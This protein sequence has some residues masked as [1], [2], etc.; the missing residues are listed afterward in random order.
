MPVT[1]AALARGTA[2]SGTNTLLFTAGGAGTIITNVV[3]AN[4]GTNGATFTMTISGVPILPA[5][6]VPAT[7]SAFF[8]IKQVVN[9]GTTVSGF[10]SNAY[11]FYH[12]SGV[13]LT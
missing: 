8:D 13:N 6:T 3:L 5:V 11:V 10:G 12:I 2:V 7:S 4:S 1:P 9:S